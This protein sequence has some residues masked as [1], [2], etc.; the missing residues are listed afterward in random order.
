MSF[1][2]SLKEAWG[3]DSETGFTRAGPHRADVRIMIENNKLSSVFSRGQIKLFVCI[4]MLAQ[5]KAL[6]SKTGIKPVV[7]L[8]D[9]NAE[10]DP[11]YS[12]YLLSLLY[13]EN[14]Q[15]FLTTTDTQSLQLTADR[16]HWFHVKQG[17]VQSVS[18][19]TCSDIN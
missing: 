17:V 4:L 14:F 10:L 1:E 3:T 19:Q 2:N 8:D 11:V 16:C 13:E 18:Q 6:Y 5:A 7:L 9:F 12:E 15:V